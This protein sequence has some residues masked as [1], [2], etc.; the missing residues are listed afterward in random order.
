[1]SLPSQLV[2]PALRMTDHP[3]AVD[4]YVRG[5]GFAVEWEHR[6]EPGFPVFLAVSRAGLRL[7]LTQH[8]G[9][10]Q[11]GGLVHFYV[12]HVDELDAEF[13]GRGVEPTEPPNDGLPG[14]RC[15]TVTDPDGNQLR[16]LTP[17]GGG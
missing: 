17:T 9:D 12:P 15:M 10:C 2:V 8:A 16:F 7:F 13:R 4:F 6:F 11:P 1:M 14:L 3:R 5:L